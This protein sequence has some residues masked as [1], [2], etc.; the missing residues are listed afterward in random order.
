MDNSNDRQQGASL[1]SLLEL[2]YD[3]IAV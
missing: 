3:I 2:T 1:Y